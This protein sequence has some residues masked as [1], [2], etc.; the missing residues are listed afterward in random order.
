MVAE[1]KRKYPLRSSP[2]I[3]NKSPRSS[4]ID[5]RVP[6]PKLPSPDGFKHTRVRRSLRHVVENESEDELNFPSPQ[7]L[8]P[9]PETDVTASPVTN[10]RG[11][12]AQNGSPSAN[13]KA[14][15]PNQSSP[16][17]NTRGSHANPNLT[18][19]NTKEHQQEA[20]H[21]EL[22]PDHLLEEVANLV[23]NKVLGTKRK[24][25]PTK[26]RGLALQTDGPITVRFNSLGQP[27]GEGSVSLSSYLGPLVRE[28]VPYTI[29]DWRKVSS[30]MKDILWTTIQTRY[31]LDKE[32][33][34]DWC[35]KE[36]AE[37]WRCSKSRL[38]R[39][40]NSLSNEEQR[41]QLKP[42]NIRSEAEWR[43]FVREKTS[44]KFQDVSS[45]FKEIRKK[46]I[47]HT[48]SRRG[49]ARTIED[50]SNSSSK[51]VSRVEAYV[52]T[53]TKKNGEPVTKEAAQ[54]LDELHKLTNEKPESGT[55]TKSAEDAL[56]T[57]FGRHKPGRCIGYGR[58]VTGTK[59][60]I[61]RER[62]D[63]IVRLEDE[64]T[65]IKN[66]MKE[67]MNILH[68][69][70]KNPSV[71]IYYFMINSLFAH[72]GTFSKGKI[73]NLAKRNFVGNK[74]TPQNNACNLLDWSGT[75]EIIAEGRWSSSDPDCTVHNLRLGPHAMRVW[76]DVVNI[77][78][79]Y[80]W[81]PNA[82]MSTIEEAVGS[83]VA[84]PAD[85]VIMRFNNKT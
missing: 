68:S 73:I 47:P 15:Q 58:G 77:P 53:H 35:M 32:W 1:R 49:Y 5:E 45:R 65:S 82:E 19:A 69:V 66:Q 9:T 74:F 6:D 42:D 72:S 40:L 67:M 30:G 29:A 28:I 79:T 57:V 81:R 33:Q 51:P 17:P 2:R 37:L 61:L 52:K 54:V 55:T 80:L 12:H 21:N 60:A 27:V 31:N 85:K 50:M 56:T 41:M 43:S 63:H 3:K 16:A 22:C 48:S 76:V 8:Q 20:V 4:N 71:R 38:V 18:D 70:V 59:L 78:G 11:N 14:N 10:P 13:A 26:M 25:G 34:R 44:K 84:W 23:T 36:M 62:D 7:N 46:Q 64:Q 39:K 83:A 24:R 75:G